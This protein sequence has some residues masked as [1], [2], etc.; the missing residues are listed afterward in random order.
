MK[1]IIVVTSIILLVFCFVSAIAEGIDLEA[2]STDDLVQ[3]Q[4]KI[5]DEL[6]KRDRFM[7]CFLNPGEYIVGEDIEPGDYLVHCVDTLNTIGKCRFA[8]VD[9]ETNK[10]I[11]HNY[12][13]RIDQLYRLNMKIGSKLVFK[14]GVIELL[15]NE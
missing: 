6:Y 7:D 5:Q 4:I 1:R 8:L 11:D 9:I 14:D 13:F 15:P 2:M 12:D 10:D 3:L